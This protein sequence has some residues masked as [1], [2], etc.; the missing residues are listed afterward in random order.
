MSDKSYICDHCG[1]L[2][3]P[4]DPPHVCPAL[5]RKHALR[6]NVAHPK[7]YTAH[8][9][10]VECIDIAEHM[11]FN[12]GNV[13]KYIWRADLKNSPIEDLRKARWYLDRE[14]QR[15]MKG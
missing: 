1:V 6:D 11:N 5:Q 14:I 7:H 8:P 2:L 3:L 4:S 10:G 9:S 13:L 15:R 12:L